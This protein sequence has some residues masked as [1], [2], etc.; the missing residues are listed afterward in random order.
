MKKYTLS[1]AE[2][3]QHRPE[4]PEQTA[5][6]TATNGFDMLYQVWPNRPSMAKTI[7]MQQS[8]SGKNI[9]SACIKL[10]DTEGF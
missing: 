8:G 4:H 2:S 6:K 9:W 1:F 7:R 5:R 10:T 3:A